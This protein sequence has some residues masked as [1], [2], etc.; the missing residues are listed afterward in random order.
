MPATAKVL[1]KR[2]Q[3]RR[4]TILAAVRKLTS[5]HGYDGLNMRAVAAEAGVSPSTLYEIYENKDS[6]ILHSVRSMFDQLGVEETELEQGLD[7]FVYRLNAI[8]AFFG[9]VPKQ[10]NAVSRLLFQNEDSELATEI[11]VANAY[12]ARRGFLDEMLSAGQITKPHDIELLT[13]SL[14]SVTWGT[15]LFC[16]RGL[17]A[18][19]DVS[20]ELVRESVALLI[21][22]A[23]SPKIARKMKKLIA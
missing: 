13:R 11:L 6:L 12:T 15:I 18:H 2:Q 9:E 5:E 10:G 1:T 23:A 20:R 3:D 19:S 4:E 8:G 21:P 7:R 14:V 22:Y 17:I 16:H